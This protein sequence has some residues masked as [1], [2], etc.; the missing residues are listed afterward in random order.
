[1]TRE[2]VLVTGASTGIGR[3]IALEFDAAG[4]HVLAGVRREA[5]AQ[6]LRAVGSPRLRPIILD[7][8]RDEDI[9]AAAVLV[10]ETTGPAGLAALVNNAGSN[11]S[12]AFEYTRPEQARALMDLNLFGLARVTQVLLPHL[13][14]AARRGRPATVVNVGSIGSV[15][16][17]PWEVW[18]HASKW[19]VLGLTLGLRHELWAEGVRVTA[20][21]PGGV[22][23]PFLA[24]S[25][26]QM[27]EAVR[28]LP[29]DA[30]ASYARGMSVR[31]EE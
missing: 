31:S 16:S 28:A 24:K 4:W 21:L 29:P 8:T 20:V 1:M 12:G 3:A 10:R 11:L 14:A 25:G 7:L 6:A 13:R 22:R 15:I 26:S 5:D 17:V 18:Y 2:H 23:T 19:A 27:D 9:D 30:P